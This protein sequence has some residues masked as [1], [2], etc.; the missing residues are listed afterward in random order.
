MLH[1]RPD[2]NRIQDPE[3]KIGE[4]EPVFLLR[5]QDTVAPEAVRYWASRTYAQ[6]GSFDL[7]RRAMEQATL[8]ETWQKENSSKVA[9]IT[10]EQ[11]SPA[12]PS[13]SNLLKHA[14]RELRIAGYNPESTD[15]VEST[16]YKNAIALIKELGNQ[17]LSGGIAPII[18]NLFY[19]LATYEPLSPL[20]GD[21]AEWRETEETE[22][23]YGPTSGQK[24]ML[25]QNIRC[26]SVFKHCGHAYDI[27]GKV[28]VD[29]NNASYTN[30]DSHIP[31]TFP[32]TH[33]PTYVHV[34][35]DGVPVTSEP[36][37]S[38]SEPSA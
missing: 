12:E 1:A 25:Y 7:T 20:I 16:V 17:H 37:V 24:G 15:F 18:L 2:Y 38:N 3:N 27:N 8:M 19:K 11:S 35:A 5:A 10:P 22:L 6:G 4:D 9:D 30:I 13:K 21:D 26:S 31:V 34:D 36:T 23:N 29:P 32:Y 28:F 33:S 14:E